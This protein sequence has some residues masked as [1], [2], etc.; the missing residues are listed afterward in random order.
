MEGG[1]QREEG[2]RERRTKRKLGRE[3]LSPNHEPEPQ[4]VLFL[5][6]FLYLPP[7]LSLPSFLPLSTFLSHSMC[8]RREAARA[9]KIYR[10]RLLVKPGPLRHTHIGQG[11]LSDIAAT[12][13]PEL[14]TQQDARLHTN[15]R[16]HTFPRWSNTMPMAYTLRTYS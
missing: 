16:S 15:A 13:D 11:W 9:S 14:A 8:L 7:S 1:T 5:H 4:L 6:T 3:R 12:P 10:D 2:E